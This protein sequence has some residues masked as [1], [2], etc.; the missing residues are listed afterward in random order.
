MD[1]GTFTKLFAIE[2]AHRIPGRAPPK[3][4]PP[5]S[6]IAK[7]LHFRDRENI[8][9]AARTGPEMSFDGYR[10]SIYPDFSAVTQKQRAS[11]QPVKK[12]LRDLNLIYSVLYPATLRIVENGKTY[13]FTNP[14][15]ALEWLDALGR[16]R[17]RSSSRSP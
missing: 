3:G 15:E 17:G 4:A 9:R 7:V 1:P 16:Q 11:F 14:T 6:M 12:R 10:I 5:R 2:R 13:F 8:L